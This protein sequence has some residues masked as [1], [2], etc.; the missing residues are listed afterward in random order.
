VEPTSGQTA[1]T[2][3][4]PEITRGQDS[5]TNP[6]RIRHDSLVEQATA[7]TPTAEIPAVEATE[8]VADDIESEEAFSTAIPTQQPATPSMPPVE[9][10]VAANTQHNLPPLE[11]PKSSTLP[12]N[13]FAASPLPPG[14][15]RYAS[16]TPLDPAPPAADLGAASPVLGPRE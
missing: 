4:D 9:D 13:P 1:E 14:N 15:D 16:A 12:T 2:I 7:E 6:L 5:G 3:P 10:E 8:S 11:Q